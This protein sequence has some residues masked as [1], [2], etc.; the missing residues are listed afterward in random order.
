L[1][2]HGTEPKGSKIVLKTMGPPRASTNWNHAQKLMLWK[3]LCS[4]WTGDRVWIFINPGNYPH[5]SRTVV[6]S[7]GSKAT[8]EFTTPRKSADSWRICTGF[9][10]SKHGPRRGHWS[11]SAISPLATFRGAQRRKNCWENSEHG[12]SR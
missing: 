10:H 5:H 7:P 9:L 6:D 4:T 8:T 1:L 2:G 3:Y 11:A 12:Q